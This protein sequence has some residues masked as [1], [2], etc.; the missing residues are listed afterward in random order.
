MTTKDASKLWRLSIDYERE[1]LRAKR[2]PT[3]LQL[4]ADELAEIVTQP[5]YA[6]QDD[7]SKPLVQL[8]AL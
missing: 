5:Y 8:E 1:R 4:L 7:G 3:V 2:R 6:N